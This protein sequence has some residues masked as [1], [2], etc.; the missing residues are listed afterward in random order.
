M[1][2]DVVIDGGQGKNPSIERFIEA[3]DETNADV[4]FVLPNNSNIIMAA[5]QASE[6]YDKSQVRVLPC[7]NFGQAYGILSMLEYNGDADEIEA[8]MLENM[9]GVTTAMVTNAIRTANI[10]GV[11]INE[12]EFIGFTDKTMLVS[13]KTKLGAFGELCEKI[14]VGEN[15]L[16][17]VV[18]GEQVDELLRER[19]AEF[20]AQT[21]PDIEFYEIDGGQEIYDYILIVE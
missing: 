18:Y 7:K 20:V 17:I 15:D 10:N 4:I 8:Q 12:G 5:K 11:E 21:Y 19:T 1:G 14:K 13:N 16:I 3:F 9:A 6:I 2:A